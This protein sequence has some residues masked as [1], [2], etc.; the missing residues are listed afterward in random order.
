MKLKKRY[1]VMIALFLAILMASESPAKVL[2]ESKPQYIKEVRVSWDMKDG[3]KAKK[4]LTDH[5]YQ[6]VDQDLNAGTGEGYSYLGYKTTTNKDEAVTD[7]SMMDMKGGFETMNYR[8][9]AEKNAPNAKQMATEMMAACQEFRDNLKAGS[10]EAKVAKAILD[11]LA[12]L[13]PNSC[14]YIYRP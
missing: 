12:N 1:L 11:L 5:G 7:I 10:P 2:A 9:M 4:W 8:S 13:I 6:V 3:T 14:H